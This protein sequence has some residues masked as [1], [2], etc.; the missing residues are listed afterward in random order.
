[1]QTA[2]R[3]FP[4]L[5]EEMWKFYLDAEIKEAAPELYKFLVLPAKD[6]DPSMAEAIK[7]A[8]RDHDKEFATAL[9]FFNDLK[10]HNFVVHTYESLKS[11][12]YVRGKASLEYVQDTN[13]I[14]FVRYVTALSYEPVL[15]AKQ[16]HPILTSSEAPKGTTE[17]P[18]V[19][20]MVPSNF[21]NIVS[22]LGLLISAALL[23]AIYQSFKYVA[24]TKYLL[25][26]FL[27]ATV[28]LAIF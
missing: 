7:Q 9:K 22:L 1:M 5:V 11:Y 12:H 15:M 20:S 18:I 10:C 23:Y 4:S 28:A 14:H 17:N 21:K 24:L 26:Q 16:L 3:D 27:G 2:L 8:L 13:Y 19:V 6:R 25:N